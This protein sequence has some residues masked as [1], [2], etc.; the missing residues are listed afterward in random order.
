[1]IE[2]VTNLQ[3]ETDRSGLRIVLELRRDANPNVI[4]NNLYKH[5]QL[6]ATFGIN[7]LALVNGQ[8]KVLNLKEMLEC[9]V[10]HQVEVLT[11]RIT[12][13]LKRAEDRSHIIE[14]F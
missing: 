3:D 1:M 14:G 6:Q 9:Y 11:R 12:Y 5:T 8:P 7:L 4:L 10:E 2:G 13:D